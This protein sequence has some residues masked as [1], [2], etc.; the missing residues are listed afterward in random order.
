M[1]RP[2]LPPFTPES[3]ATKIRLAEDAWNSRDPVRVSL[4]YT[5]DS[6]WRNPDQFLTG[7]QAIVEFLHLKW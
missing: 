7:R 3:A 4:A 1:Q 5:E 2:P 6:I